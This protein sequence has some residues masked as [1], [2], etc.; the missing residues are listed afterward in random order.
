MDHPQ[1]P[2]RLPTASPAAF[3][4]SRLWQHPRTAVD[5]IFEIA[6]TPDLDSPLE[7]RARG[8][9]GPVRVA[10]TRGAQHH[11]RRT[12]KKIQPRRHNSVDAPSFRLCARPDRSSHHLPGPRRDPTHHLG[13][14]SGWGMGRVLSWR[15]GRASHRLCVEQRTMAHLSRT[16]RGDSGSRRRIPVAPQRPRYRTAEPTGMNP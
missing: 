4:P 14:R 3:P 10:R 16:R 1:T 9:P 7:R 13:V 5:G 11:H 6:A 12:T 2:G 15:D 8:K